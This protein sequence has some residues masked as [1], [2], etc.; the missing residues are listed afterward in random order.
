MTAFKPGD[1]V[2]V[3]TKSDLS[4]LNRWSDYP[5]DL[6]TILVVKNTESGCLYFDYITVGC[7]HW[8]FVPAF[9]DKPLEDYL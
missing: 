3:K 1:L 2:R 7:F 8:R 4:Y 6:N 5:I 9:F